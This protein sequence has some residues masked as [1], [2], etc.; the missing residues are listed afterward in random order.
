MTE[1][2]KS[3]ARLY[4]NLGIAA[5]GL[6]G[7]GLGVNLGVKAL[8]GRVRRMRVRNAAKAV[9]GAAA[10]YA[11]T[12]AA[13]YGVAF[14]ALL[15]NAAK[16]ARRAGHH[17]NPHVILDHTKHLKN[18]GLTGK[19]RTKAQVKK[20]FREAAFKHH[21]DRGGDAERMKDI[22]NSYDAVKNSHWHHKLAHLKGYSMENFWTGFEK[23]AA[24][25]RA[26]AEVGGL[27]VLALPSIQKLRGKPMNEDTA[28]KLEVLGLGTLAAPELHHLG[29]AAWKKIAPKLVP[30]AQGGIK[31]FVKKH[32]EPYTKG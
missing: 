29:G 15:A 21:P 30:K 11:G 5:A 23:E 3:K 31:N 2:K 6:G 9:G 18:L 32:I 14:A 10:T 28:A 19:E 8:R 25:A 7:A 26:I 4:E 16:N 27:G 17:V 12:V 20:V 22:L 1:R 13:T 24:N